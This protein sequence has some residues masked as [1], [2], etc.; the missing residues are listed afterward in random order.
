MSYL[1]W[2]FLHVGSVILFLGNIT[3]GM[4]WGAYANRSRD[5]R[6]IASTFDGIILSDRV[7][8]MP[9]VIVIVVSGV[10]A[11]IAGGL[12]ILGTGWILWGILLFVVAGIV[13]GRVVAPL[14]RDIV[15]LAGSGNPDE[16]N[17]RTYE[18]LYAR[19]ARWGLLAVLAPA[20]AV[21]IMVMKPV[22][23]AF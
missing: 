19:W 18:A 9:G 14:Q 15:R 2:K 6:L 21:L 4:F 23:P 11:A 3:T 10:V 5:F 16:Q 22:L 8:T 13:F 1:I 7:F 12:P 17:W 20:A